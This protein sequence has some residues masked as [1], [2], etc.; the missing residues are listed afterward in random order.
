M[1]GNAFVPK[2]FSDGHPVCWA[3][4]RVGLCLLFLIV[5]PANAQDKPEVKRPV[6]VAVHPSTIALKEELTVS[7]NDPDKWLDTDEARRLVL[8]LNGFALKNVKGRAGPNPG[9]IIFRLSRDASSK[10]EWAALLARPSLTPRPTGLQV[11]LE[12]QAPFAGVQA[13]TLSTIDA[14]YLA[15]FLGALAILL[16]FFVM[17]AAKS[18]LIREGQIA[19]PP[20]NRRP[21][22]LGRTQMAV[23]FFVVIASFMFIW[24]V[25]GAYDPLTT[26]VLALIGISAGTAMSAAL[27]DSNKQAGVEN[28]ATTLDQERRRLQADIQALLQTVTETNALIA[29]PVAGTDVPALQQQVVRHHAEVAAKT[30]RTQQIDA[31]LRALAVAVQPR[32]SEGFIDDILSDDNGVSFHR[33][34][35]AVWTL[36]LGIV[37]VYTV[38]D[39]LAMPDF[40]AKLLGLLGIS[41][42]TYLGFKFPETK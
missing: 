24:I 40:D 15:V 12:G 32:V 7:L 19:P 27:V 14:K 33:F 1:I 10:G 16:V 31:E 41:A 37:F 36:V 30:V 18:D 29:A 13:V 39:G 3:A 4:C 21:F 9:Q 17:L 38:Y 2:G 34:Q 8:F 11:G 25:T 5:A 23:W 6:L 20:G 42:G 28:R 35:I 26:S 22:S